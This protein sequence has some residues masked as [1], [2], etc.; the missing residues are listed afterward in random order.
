MAMPSDEDLRESGKLLRHVKLR[1]LQAL[2]ARAKDVRTL[3]M[4]ARR[5]HA[6]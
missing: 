1:S 6:G 2:E 3:V 5:M 4:A